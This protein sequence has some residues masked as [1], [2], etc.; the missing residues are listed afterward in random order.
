MAD[1]EGYIAVCND[2]RFK[3]EITSKYKAY[4]DRQDHMNKK[5]SHL[6][7]VKIVENRP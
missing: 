7:R 2:C 3:G 5:P 6:V 4:K 1:Q